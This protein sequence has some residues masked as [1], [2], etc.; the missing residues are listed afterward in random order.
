[1]APKALRYLAAGS[2]KDP[3]SP[4]RAFHFFYQGFLGP[5]GHLHSGTHILGNRTDGLDIFRDRDLDHCYP[6]VFDANPNL[7]PGS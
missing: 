5:F 6:V 4:R 3:S 1:M 2:A 7:F